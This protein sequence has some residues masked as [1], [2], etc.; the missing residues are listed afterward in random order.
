MEEAKKKHSFGW[1]VLAVVIVSFVVI[2]LIS[3]FGLLLF[4]VAV[5][6]LSM[7]AVRVDSQR[8]RHREDH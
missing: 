5:I 2:S 3:R 8:R 7:L 6:G 1:F 4:V